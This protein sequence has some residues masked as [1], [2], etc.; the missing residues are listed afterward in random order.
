MSRIQRGTR[1]YRLVTLALFLGA[2]SVYASLYVTQ[3]IL[4][5]LSQDFGINPAQASLSLS[6]A[7]VSMAFSQ[8]L[9]GPVADSLG[10][11]PI[12]TLAVLLT[13]VIGLAA[14]RMVGFNGFL[15]TRFLQGLVMAGLP[16]TA[17]AYLAEEIDTRH[18]GA[19]MGLYISGNSLGGLGGRI[20]SGSVAEF[21]GW[22]GALGA[23]GLVSLVCALWFARTLPPSR[24]F[25]AQPLQLS[26][27]AR[28]LLDA[29]RDP[30]LRTLYFVGFV[31]LG[32]FVALYNYVSYHLMAPPYSLSAALVGWIYV[33]YLFGTVSAAWM[34]RL[35][36]RYGRAP[37]LA[38]GLGIQLAGAAISLA[39]P[40]LLK[41]GGIAVFTFGFFGAH[42]IASSWVGQRALRDKGAAS[43]LYLLTYYLGASIAGTVA[44]LFWMRFGWPGVVGFIAC[45]LLAGLGLAALARRLS[46]PAE[47]VGVVK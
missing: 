1:E 40:L 29:F 20:I 39:G 15:F 41:I 35:S 18:L 25:R 6:V 21:W 23:I 27:L 37:M 30:L 43:A 11:K 26:R 44:G 10:R 34:G 9:V 12:M 3:P 31:A 2:L 5:L 45:L 46:A 33:L 47:G 22:R 36:D 42:S 7:T 8:V 24:N 17:M 4:P 14:S 32:S 19:A 38:L 16:A 13:G 28:S